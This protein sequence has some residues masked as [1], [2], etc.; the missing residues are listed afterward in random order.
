M[1]LDNTYFLIGIII[2]VFIVF[3][4]MNNSKPIYRPVYLDRPVYRPVYVD[5][6]IFRR[7]YIP[8][9][10]KHPNKIHPVKPILPQMHIDS[11]KI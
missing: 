10:R 5:R 3:T 2:I 7:G 6:P 8:H 9:R 4:Y 1:K 11:R